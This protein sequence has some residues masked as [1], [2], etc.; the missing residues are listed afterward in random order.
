MDEKTKHHPK[1]GR[2]ML[3][4]LMWNGFKYGVLWPMILPI[5]MMMP[6]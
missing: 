6:W 1:G 3:L 4:D 2:T 5:K